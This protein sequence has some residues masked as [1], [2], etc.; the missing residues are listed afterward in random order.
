MKKPVSRATAL[1]V[2]T[3][4]L[5]INGIVYAWSIYSAPFSENFGW[6]S[7]Q[8]GVC[9]TLVLV[10]FCLGGFFGSMITG[11]LGAG[12]TIPAGGLLSAVGYIVCLALGKDR[13]LLLYVCFSVAGLGSGIAYNAVLSNVTSRF[14][15]KRGTASGVMLMGFG[16]STL[17]MGSLAT[18]LIATVG[19]QM[20]YVV[21]ATLLV[22]ISLAGGIILSRGVGAASAAAGNSENAEGLTPAQ[23]VRTS[24][25]WLL[26]ASATVNAFFGFG[27]LGHARYIAIECGLA[28]QVAT[29][30]VGLVSVMNGLGRIIFGMIHD[31]K[32]I[33]LSF[34]IS[35]VAFILASGF[36]V[37]GLRSASPVMT[38]IGLMLGGFGNS[39]APTI[40]TSVA[41]EFFGKANYGK[42]MSILNMHMLPASLGSTVVGVLQTANS[43]YA[44]AFGMFGALELIPLSLIFI[45]V[46]T[47]KNIK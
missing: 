38:A 41:A 5:F 6:T 18:K 39:A 32:G 27:V 26:F 13:L 43:T 40:V 16:T 35:S 10:F 34:P 14:P 45:L 47:R 29:L 9:F 46:K 36:I 4:V 44:S 33:R 3:L 20:T 8:L 11:R 2:G 30:V 21:T 24:S 19:W 17:I 42:N 12:K 22:V 31:R 28:G 7:A 1:I 37:L 23:M 15:D 25:F